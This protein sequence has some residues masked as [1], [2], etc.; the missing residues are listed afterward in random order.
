MKT[1]NLLRSYVL[2]FAKR[3]KNRK[4]YKEIQRQWLEERNI[5]PPLSN[6][7]LV[8]LS[9]DLLDSNKN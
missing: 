5:R 2:A 6:S 8:Y 3:F 9:D 4:Y 1:L 7:Y